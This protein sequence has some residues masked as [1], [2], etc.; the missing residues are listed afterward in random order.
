MAHVVP[1]ACQAIS[2]KEKHPWEAKV[3]RVCLVL[4]VALLLASCDLGTLLGA[5]KQGAQEWRRIRPFW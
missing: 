3:K 5:V 1:K 2:G 4:I